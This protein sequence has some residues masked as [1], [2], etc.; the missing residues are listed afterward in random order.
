MTT[1]VILAGKLGEPSFDTLRGKVVVTCPMVTEEQDLYILKMTGSDRL[2]WLGG[3]SVIVEGSVNSIGVLTC[4]SVR[5]F[6]TH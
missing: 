5:K 1:R 6:P 4:K 3:E 2:M